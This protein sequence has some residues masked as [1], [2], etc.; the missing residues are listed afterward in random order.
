MIRIY[1]Y[2]EVSK[3]EIF[4]RENIDAGVEGIVSD[5]IANVIKRGDEALFDIN[6]LMRNDMEV[7]YI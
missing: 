4:A 5:I 1:K 7:F 3:D 6:P 2:G